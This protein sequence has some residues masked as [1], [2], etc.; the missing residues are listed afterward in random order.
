M[1]AA[2]PAASHTPVQVPLPGD[3]PIAA[4]VAAPVPAVAAGASGTHAARGQVDPRWFLPAIF[5]GSIALYAVGSSFTFASGGGGHE[6]ALAQRPEWIFRP[7]HLFGT[8]LLRLALLLAGA[9]GLA[10]RAVVVT[11]VLNV[12]LA[13]AAVTL[14][15]ILLRRL[16]V[17][18]PAALVAALVLAVSNAFWEH[19][20]S[21]EA[22]VMAL[23]FALGALAIAAGKPAVNRRIRGWRARGLLAT[24]LFCLS[25][26]LGGGM[27]LLL[28]ALL[29]LVGRQAPAGERGTAMARAAALAII[30]GLGPFLLVAAI[31]GHDSWASFV[32][33][34]FARTEVE[35][36]AAVT[37]GPL[38]LPRAIAGI[39]RLMFA[40]SDGESALRALL[41]GDSP[42]AS[43]GD[44][45]SLLRNLL[46][47]LTLLGLAAR[48]VV[49]LSRGPLTSGLALGL[50]APVVLV[51]GL[52]TWWLSSDPGLW[53]PVFPLLLG[54]AAL[55]LGLPRARVWKGVGKGVWKGGALAAG[56]LLFLSL[57]AANRCRQ[58]PSLLCEQGGPEWRAAA[59]V[60]RLTTGADLVMGPTGSELLWLPHVRPGARTLQF[61]QTIPQSV[62][63]V[64]YLG[65]IWSAVQDTLASGGRVYVQG[66]AD[67]S[68]ARLTGAWASMH[69]K[70]GVSRDELRRL[71]E[72]EFQRRP[73]P[74]LGTAVDELLPRR[75]VAE[76]LR[77]KPGG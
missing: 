17:T 12:A 26:T 77:L 33:W 25:V 74:E 64:D 21:G 58:A 50:A 10:A 24:V 2:M 30:L 47:A 18:R 29:V 6:I 13:A 61:D 5:L 51:A 11:N 22:V 44:R 41:M 65:E 69:S 19:A 16:D 59:Q 8:A 1:S 62:D 23:P 20:T 15:Y 7:E 57:G 39:G 73:A 75:M 45:F 48:G 34:L 55:G 52:G 42:S 70:H 31:L 38:Q 4:T 71:M 49:K 32:A 43:L 67:A 63:A 76:A 54:L 46:A 53:L 37:G 66:L 14:L 3:P 72:R 40:P 9:L 28:P 56:A 27:A 35:A 60:A 68:P 36:L